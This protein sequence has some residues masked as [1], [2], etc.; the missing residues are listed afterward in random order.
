MYPR[1]RSHTKSSRNLVRLA[2]D[3][4]IYPVVLPAEFQIEAVLKL[5]QGCILVTGDGEGGGLIPGRVRLD[6]VFQRVVVEVVCCY[7]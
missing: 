2:R 4:E 6:L 7:F 5:A 3:E 1:V